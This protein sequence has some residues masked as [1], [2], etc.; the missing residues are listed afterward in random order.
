MR[1]LFVKMKYVIFMK[2][3][4]SMAEKYIYGIDCDKI[5]QKYLKRQ[6]IELYSHQCHRDIVYDSQVKGKNNF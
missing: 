6:N 2:Y 4:K 3:V 5:C 1:K